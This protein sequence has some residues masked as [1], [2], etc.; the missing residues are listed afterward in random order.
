MARSD[1]DQP[2][3]TI[4]QTCQ[5]LLAYRVGGGLRD[6][7]QDPEAFAYQDVNGQALGPPKQMRFAFFRKLARVLCPLEPYS[8]SVHGGA[9]GLKSYRMVVD[10]HVIEMASPG[11][12]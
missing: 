3:P 12:A 7:L 6:T 11:S 10:A 4:S 1:V 9:L 8:D 5:E 2:S